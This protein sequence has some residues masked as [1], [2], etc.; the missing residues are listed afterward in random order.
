MGV[1]G[2]Q[3]ASEEGGFES[4]S[5]SP[6]PVL[7]HG[8]FPAQCG[9]DMNMFPTCFSYFLSLCMCVCGGGRGKN[10]AVLGSCVVKP[11]LALCQAS[12]FTPVLLPGT[13]LVQGLSSLLLSSLSG[14]NCSC[15]LRM[16]RQT[17]LA[18]WV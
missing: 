15:M 6:V 2:R 5:R 10:V 16:Q 17:V 3:E 14:P 11:G 12:A 1:Q 18:L 13:D 9:P 4:L 7:Y 8:C